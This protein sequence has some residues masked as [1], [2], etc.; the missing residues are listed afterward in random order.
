MI[1]IGIHQTTGPLKNIREIHFYL[2]QNRGD[3]AF[4]SISVF[5]CVCV[6]VCV[7]VC[8]FV[9]ALLFEPFDV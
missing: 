8:V 2:P 1:Y 3:N 9:G 6:R 4:G 7:C 5:V